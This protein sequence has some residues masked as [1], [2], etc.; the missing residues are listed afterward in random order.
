MPAKSV[1]PVDLAV[2]A[3]I[4][5]ITYFNT[6]KLPEHSSRVWQDISDELKGLWKVP[7]VRINVRQNRRKILT[8]AREKCGIFIQNNENISCNLNV[9]SASSDHSNTTNDLNDNDSNN[10]EKKN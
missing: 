6:D 8:L 2:N 7:T 10:N 5:Y 9:S 1:V 3:L 4:K